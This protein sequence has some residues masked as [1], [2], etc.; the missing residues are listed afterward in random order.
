MSDAEDLAKAAKKKL[1]SKYKTKS[2]VGHSVSV[3][4]NMIKVTNSISG[5]EEEF[6]DLV[7]VVK[8][9]TDRDFY[10]FTDNL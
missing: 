9:I 10:L 4:H 5:K 2:Y 8:D 6:E 7:Y 1:F 3:D